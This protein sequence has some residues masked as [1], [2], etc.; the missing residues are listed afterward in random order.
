MGMSRSGNHAMVRWLEAHYRE[1]GFR[2]V[3]LNNVTRPFLEDLDKEGPD[4]V[5][6]LVSLEDR[7]AMVDEELSC[8]TASADHNVL[9]LRDPLNLFASRVEGL[10][11]DRGV[12]LGAGEFGAEERMAAEEATIRGLPEQVGMYMNHH[13]E[14]SGAT[15]LLRNRVCV[16]YNG[17]V[18]DAS[19]RRALAEGPFGLRFSDSCYMRREGSSFGERAWS[20]SDYLGRW[21]SCWDLPVYAP[22]RGD[23]ALVDIARGMGVRV[24]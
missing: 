15:S 16:S 24:P 21:R 8:L 7:N 12:F 10:G 19:Y 9:L 6:R 13:A 14:F 17:W 1:A 20:E 4:D 11:P 22:V 23:G 18:A 5:V 2:F 3:F